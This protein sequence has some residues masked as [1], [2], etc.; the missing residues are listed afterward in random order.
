MV[1]ALGGAGWFGYSRLGHQRPAGKA[2][3]ISTHLMELV[4][5]DH[6][7]V[8]VP[9]DVAE[10]MQLK[11]APVTSAPPR[12]PLVMAG[13]LILDA[14]RMINIHSR[15]PGEVVGI[16]SVAD[17]RPSPVKEQSG[18]RPLQFGDH[19]EKGQLLAIVWCRDVGEKKSDLVDAL[20]RLAQS[21]LTLTRLKGLERGTVAE[22]TVREAQ[23]AH[24]ADVILVERL[25]RTLRSWRLADEEL[26]EVHAE[27]DRIKSGKREAEADLEKKWGEI[28]IRAPFAGTILEKNVVVGD[29]IESSSDLFKIA[30]LSRLGAMANVYE[31]DL[32]DLHSLKPS[33]RTWGIQVP[34]TPEEPLIHGEFNVIGKVIDV[35]QHSGKVLGWVDN[36]GGRLYVGQFITAIVK[37]P[38]SP[39]EVAIPESAILEDTPLSLVFVADPTHKHRFTARRVVLVRHH[40][41][42][43]VVAAIPN[44]QQEA[45]GA[46]P[47]Q[48]GETVLSS[49]AL[50]MNS[51]L[52]DL[53]N[54]LAPA[55][56]AARH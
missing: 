1:V 48:A 31:E 53:R 25:E 16:G 21:E 50:E 7:S 30:D 11:T 15:F 20:T 19:I 51:Q 35:T 22:L 44:A 47:L 9:A 28:E 49:G 39:R 37:L 14:D 18:N 45:Q 41:G 6:N 54:R 4:D 12:A 55:H 2:D 56:S 5:G 17:L 26:A 34:A 10:I 8:D 29:I 23:R 24:E 46:E 36:R 3:S 38:P 33:E 13:S 27:A 42:M 40:R 43:A 52:Q 32:A